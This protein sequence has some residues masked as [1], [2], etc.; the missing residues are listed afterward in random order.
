VPAHPQSCGDTQWRPGR[1]IIKR[2]VLGPAAFP[3]QCA[4]GLT[5]PQSEISVWLHGIGAP[6]DVTATNVIAGTQPI[7]TQY[8]Y[9]EN[10]MRIDEY[11]A[12]SASSGW[13]RSRLGPRNYIYSERCILRITVCRNRDSG[14]A[15]YTT[16]TRSGVPEADRL[17]PTFVCRSENWIACSPFISAHAPWFW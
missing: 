1:E 17:H 14:R 8:W 11:L 5:A 16:S 6:R 9:F 2:L 4:V 12:K 3:H 10:R 15:T 7:A 13:T